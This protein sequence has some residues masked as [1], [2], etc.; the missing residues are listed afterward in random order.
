MLIGNLL[1]HTS[2]NICLALARSVERFIAGLSVIEQQKN[3]AVCV[4]LLARSLAEEGNGVYQDALDQSA[5]AK[6][7]VIHREQSS[8]MHEI[9]HQMVDAQSCAAIEQRYESLTVC[10]RVQ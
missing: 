8:A 1:S 2:R 6:L 7:S 3:S 9:D 10:M 5:V 4:A